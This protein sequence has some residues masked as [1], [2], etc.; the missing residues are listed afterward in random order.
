MGQS[1]AVQ[2]VDSPEQPHSGESR[3]RRKQQEHDQLPGILERVRG[4]P[5][6]QLLADDAATGDGRD[7]GGDHNGRKVTNGEAAEDHLHRKQ[8]PSDRGV[9]TGADARPGPGR[10][11]APDLIRSEAEEPRDHRPDGTS[12]L[13]DRALATAGSPSAEREGRRHDL[14]RDHPA[15]NSSVADAE[16]R[17]H[18][19]D[20]VP[21]DFR[22]ESLCDPPRHQE[23]QGDRDQHPPA[24]AADQALDGVESLAN[25]IDHQDEGGRANSDAHPDERRESQE[26]GRIAVGDDI[27][28]GELTPAPDKGPHH[29]TLKT[30]H[31]GLDPGIW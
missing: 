6:R 24:P 2:Q 18:V 7:N 1:P 22:R 12:N 31:R 9:E 21:F 16:G 23:S 17:D 26:A 8:H 20:P 3:H 15:T 11:Q 25:P 27:Y 30:C 13:H 4:G 10:H 14:G 5:D 19:W 28:S 29:A